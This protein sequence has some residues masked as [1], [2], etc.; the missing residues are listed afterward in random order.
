ESEKLAAGCPRIRSGGTLVGE[1][2]AASGE[3]GGERIREVKIL[4]FVGVGEDNWRR[5][6]L[7]VGVGEDKWRWI[8]LFV[9]IG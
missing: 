2:A 3:S 1:F 4:L 8:L 5:I 7:F 9:G 6:L